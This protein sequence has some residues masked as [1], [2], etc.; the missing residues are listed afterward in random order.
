MWFRGLVRTIL[1]WRTRTFYIDVMAFLGIDVDRVIEVKY[2]D[3]L[4]KIE[5]RRR[6]S[7]YTL[8]GYLDGNRSEGY[9]SEVVYGPELL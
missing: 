4:S 8:S 1:F 5:D 2:G 7:P 3:S 6:L 9:R